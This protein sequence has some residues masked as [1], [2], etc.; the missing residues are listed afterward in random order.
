MKFH[1]GILIQGPAIMAPNFFNFILLPAGLQ[2]EN[3]A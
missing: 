2:L 1:Q 3:S